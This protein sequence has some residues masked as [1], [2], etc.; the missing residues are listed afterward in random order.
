M[1]FTTGY[2]KLR[3]FVKSFKI[4]YAML[5]VQLVLPPPLLLLLMLFKKLFFA[6]LHF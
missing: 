2:I 1:C 6:E 4:Y 5:M 3:F